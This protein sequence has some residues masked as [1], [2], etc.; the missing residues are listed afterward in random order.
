MINLINWLDHRTYHGCVACEDTRITRRLY[1]G[2]RLQYRCRIAHF[3]SANVID[4]E[5]PSLNPTQTVMH[6]LNDGNIELAGYRAAVSVSL[7]FRW[8]DIYSGSWRK[9]PQKQLSLSGFA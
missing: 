1:V 9:L 8:L 4:Q 6:S 3:S 5:D 2:G 7:P